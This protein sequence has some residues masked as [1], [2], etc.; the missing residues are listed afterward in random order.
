MKWIL[1]ATFAV[2]L[3]LGAAFVAGRSVSPTPAATPTISSEVKRSEDANDVLA[4]SMKPELEAA[5]T[6]AP[7][8][9]ADHPFVIKRILPIEGPIKYGQWYWDDS[10]V[11]DGPIVITVDLDARVISVFRDGYEIGAS[12]VL[13]GTQDHPTPLGV[14]PILEKKKDNYSSIYDNAPMPYTM[15][16]TWDGVSIHGSKVQNGYASHGCIGAPN[17]FAAKLFA[18]AKKGDKVIITKGKTATIGDPLIIN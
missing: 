4:T 7:A 18:I 5:S 3:G 8:I 14:F 17:P 12:A 1:G 6:S 10:D 2:A 16:L 13:L 9:D 15:R 11:P